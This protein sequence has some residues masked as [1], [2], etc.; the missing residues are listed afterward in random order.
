MVWGDSYAMQLVDGIEAANPDRALVQATRS[1][2]GPFLGLTH[3][4]RKFDIVFAASCFAFNQ[5]VLDNLATSAA[6]RRRRAGG[7]VWPISQ[8]AVAAGDA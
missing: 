4:S 1:N 8:S 2:C 6:D 7:P 5:A 3:F